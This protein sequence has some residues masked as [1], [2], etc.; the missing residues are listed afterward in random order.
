M[1]MPSILSMLLMHQLAGS[2]RLS[3]SRK[4][5]PNLSY[6]PKP[7]C[8]FFLLKAIHC[9][10]LCWSSFDSALRCSSSP[11][12]LSFLLFEAASGPDR[13]LR[14]CPVV[15]CALEAERYELFS[16]FIFFWLGLPGN[17]CN[18]AS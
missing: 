14:P 9:R 11:S 16:S 2:A 1:S 12:N 17:L 8:P 4:P 6:V 10:A 5:F 15:N 18:G 13:A 3:L 7:T